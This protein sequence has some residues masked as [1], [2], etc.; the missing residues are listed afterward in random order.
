MEKLGKK[1]DL[2]YPLA[3]ISADVFTMG[4]NLLR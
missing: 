4:I 2:N 1:T 3:K